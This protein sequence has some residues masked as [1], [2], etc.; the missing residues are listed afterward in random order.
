MGVGVQC[1]ARAVVAQGVGKGLHIHT[2][3]E[4]QCGEGMPLWHNKDKSDNPCGAMGR[5][6]C[7]CSFSINLSR[8]NRHD[9]GCQKVRCT[10]KDK[11]YVYIQPGRQRPGWVPFIQVIVALV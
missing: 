11:K 6:V 9:E 8:K 2:V 4:G 3:L 5:T 7:P 10:I 1:E